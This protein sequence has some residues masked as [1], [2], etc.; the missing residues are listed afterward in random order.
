M[1]IMSRITILPALTADY[2]DTIMA[3]RIRA[4]KNSDTV[5][6]MLW[7][8][9]LELQIQVNG[10][11]RTAKYYIPRNTPQGTAIVIMNVPEG[12]ATIP[13][14]E[15][16]G[17]IKQA[18]QE[19]FCLFVLEPNQGGWGSPEEEEAYLREGV[20]AEMR[21]QYCLAAFA[22]YVVGYGA[23]GVGLHKI[24]MA[25]PLHVAA[26][27]FLD[28]GSVDEEYRKEY[29]HKRFLEADNYDPEA[30]GLCVPYRDI[31]VPVWV[32]TGKMDAATKAMIGYWRKATKADDPRENAFGTT[33]AQCAPTEYTPQGDILKV[34]IQTRS[35]DYCNC[36]TTQEIYAFL[37]QYYRYG[38]G[39]HSN[40]ISKRVDF[41]ALGTER[42]FFTDSNGIHREYLVYVP[43]AY[44]GG[45]KKLPMVVAYHGASQSM[46]NM[47][48][49]GLWYEIAER[50]G[51]IVVYPE[52]TLVSLPPEL[53]GGGIF[54]Y[55]PLWSLENPA[56]QHTELDYANEMLD[57]VNAEF[58]VDQSRIYCTGHSMGCMMTNYLGS[59]EVS[60]RFAAVGATSGC[61]KARESSGTQPIPAFM[62]MGQFDLW[63]YLVS[64]ESPVTAEIDMWLVRNGLATKDDVHRIRTAKATAVYKQ[65]RYNN[66]VWKDVDGTPWVRY[67][68][69][70]EKHHVHTSDENNTFWSQWFSRWHM[71]QDGNRL[72]DGSDSAGEG[73]AE[74]R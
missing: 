73:C 24:V 1:G 45:Q 4:T 44:R 21:G 51:I 49:N 33:Y 59:S 72:Y 32:A 28:A 23:I 56:N 66:Y 60:H 43:A 34:A 19:G 62:T 47:M 41:E 69:I 50:E 27:A 13:F 55:R 6:P 8:G 65:G 42:K 3:E 74:L 52:S 48:A 35:Y 57:R 70:S 18:D 2:L 38:M 58:P 15:K 67:A 31:P 14:L 20:K 39:P 7:Q 36:T 53:N 10:R 22:A 17:W 25:D 61:L 16:S 12:E 26:A 68:W 29:E 37:K 71:D 63:S 64:D 30:E 5:I 40:M 9:I 54:A 46:R 11:V